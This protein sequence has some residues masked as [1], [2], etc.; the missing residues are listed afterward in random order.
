MLH[1]TFGSAWCGAG[2]SISVVAVPLQ[3][4]FRNYYRSIEVLLRLFHQ[5]RPDAL[6]VGHYDIGNA[7]PHIVELPRE[8]PYDPGMIV[9]PGCLMRGATKSAHF[10]LVGQIAVIFAGVFSV[11]ALFRNR[12][13]DDE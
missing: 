5:V 1:R 4:I 11:L 2:V 7:C 9:T 13:K 6:L 3:K 12:G 8:R 10:D